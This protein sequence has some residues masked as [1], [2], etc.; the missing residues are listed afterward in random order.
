LVSVLDIT[1]MPMPTAV[2][3]SNTSKA[4]IRATPLSEPL[5]FFLWSV[6]MVF[7]YWQDSGR[8]VVA[9]EQLLMDTSPWKFVSMAWFV[10]GSMTRLLRICS[11]SL[12]VLIDAMVCAASADVLMSIGNEVLAIG[13]PSAL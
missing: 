5:V 4:M 1:I 10:L 6:F 2:I 9:I 8:P 7:S 3:S 12:M 11:V 13:V